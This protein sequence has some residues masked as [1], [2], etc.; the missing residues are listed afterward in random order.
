MHRYRCVG[1]LI[2]RS[3]IEG[4]REYR[5]QQKFAIRHDGAYNALT[6][7]ECVATGLL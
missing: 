7:R 2:L 1:A 4:V 6:A 5:M 3:E